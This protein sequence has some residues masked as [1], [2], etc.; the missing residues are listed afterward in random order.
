MR[1]GNLRYSAAGPALLCA[2]FLVFHRLTSINGREARAAHHRLSLGAL[3]SVNGF[4]R[5]PLRDH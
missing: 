4:L 1:E 5:L 2:G 3:G